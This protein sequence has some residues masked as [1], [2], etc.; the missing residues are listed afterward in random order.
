[1]DDKALLSRNEALAVLEEH[2]VPLD[3]NLTN[4]EV[5]HWC[6][7]NKERLPYAPVELVRAMFPHNPQNVRDSLGGSDD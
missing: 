5:L 6:A 2:G 1:M 3:L 7:A 4:R